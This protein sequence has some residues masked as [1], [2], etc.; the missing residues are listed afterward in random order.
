MM[1]TD[2][3]YDELLDVW[4]G[5]FSPDVQ[6]IIEDGIQ[7]PSD[8]HILHKELA[9]ALLALKEAREVVVELLR[10]VGPY[11]PFCG[12]R[13]ESGHAADCKLAANL[14]PEAK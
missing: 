6:R 13:L 7:H 2:T 4:F 9:T 1:L 10:Y 5:I 11:C 8:E 3:E 14:A 12:V